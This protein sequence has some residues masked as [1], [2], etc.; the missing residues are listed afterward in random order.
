MTEIRAL[1]ATE[2]DACLPE[3]TDLLYACVQAGASISFVLPFSKADAAIFWSEKTRPGVACGTRVLL[4]ARHEGTI[5]GT[6]QLD[7]D[8]PPN[9]PHRADV[10]KL[11]VHPDARRQGTAKALMV[12]L[13]AA[14][15]R[16]G[17]NLLTLDTRT[18][19][20]AEPLY[21]GLGYRI[22]GVIPEYALNTARDGQHSTT[23]FYKALP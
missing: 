2:L 7:C 15:H 22:V 21:L 1:S 5:T 19:D 4:V 11:M 13:E 12:A 16:L 8:T 14:A 10:C 9:Q 17:R 20:A 3:L 18:G 6:V 23:I